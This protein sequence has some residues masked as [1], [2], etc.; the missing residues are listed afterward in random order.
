VR[1]GHRRIREEILGE[2][3]IQQPADTSAEFRKR[4]FE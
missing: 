4:R 3:F 1:P 2:R